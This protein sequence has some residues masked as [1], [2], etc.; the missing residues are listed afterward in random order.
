VFD[1]ATGQTIAAVPEADAVDVDQAVKAA[2]RAFETG[3]W[4]KTSPQ[5]R[6]KLM[7]KL[8]DLQSG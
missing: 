1:P 8:A 3:P 2:G 6:C 4:S 7:W 5:D